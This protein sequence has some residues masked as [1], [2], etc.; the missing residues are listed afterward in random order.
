M[1][2]WSG[3]VGSIVSSGGAKKFKGSYI[4][5]MILRATVNVPQLQGDPNYDKVQCKKTLFYLE[6][7]K[8]ALSDYAKIWLID[9]FSR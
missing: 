3:L 9:F 5:L 8:E 7:C 1:V 4:P 6:T 2:H